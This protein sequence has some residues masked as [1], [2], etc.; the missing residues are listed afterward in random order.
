[1]NIKATG[2]KRFHCSQSREAE[3]YGQ[4][5]AGPGIKNDCPGEVYPNSLGNESIGWLY[6]A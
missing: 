5:T 2:N 6:L 3:K 4:S 1:M